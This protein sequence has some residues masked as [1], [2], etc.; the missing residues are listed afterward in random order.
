MILVVGAT[1][2]LGG[3]ITMRL[4]ARERRVRILVRPGTDFGRLVTAGAEPVHGDLKD[5]AS[6]ALAL[7]LACDGVDA[8]VTTANATARGGDDTIETVDRLGNRHLIDAA[9]EAGVRKFVF[10]S[11]LGADPN[12][13]LPLLAAKGE[14]ERHL[15]ASGMA[16]TVLQPNLLFDKLPMLVVGIPALSGHTVTLVGEGRRVH[17]LIAMDDV[18]A[19]AVAA[20]EQETAN[21]QTLVIGGPAAVSWRDVVDAF[22][23]ELGRDVKVR[24]V[25]TDQPIP[26]MPDFIRDL[27]RALETYDSPLDTT[28]ADTYGITLTT[29]PEFVRQVVATTPTEP[30]ATQESA[31]G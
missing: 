2:Q 29:L 10:V 3:L 13:P 27:L 4:L 6:L 19:Y 22:S 7:A 8:V 21:G 12:S 23:D 24:V 15:R 16:W 9:S 31:G 14:A 18:A 28:L 5:P 30:R 25:P 26:G 17:S 1:G 20:L 11:S